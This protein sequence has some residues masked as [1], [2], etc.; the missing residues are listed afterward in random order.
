MKI[1][2]DYPLRRAAQVAADVLALVVIALGIWLGATVT[3]AIAV[4]GEVGRQLNLAGLGFQGAMADAANVLGQAPFIG[5]AA[6]A[7]FDSAS[8]TGAVIA[9]AGSSTESFILTTAAIVGVIIALAI[10][11]AVLWVW[12]RRRIA[13]IRRA[14]EA[15]RLATMGDG[16]DLLALRALVN[17]S[18]ADLAATSAH[19]VDAWRSGE[20]ALVRKLAALELRGAG[21]RPRVSPAR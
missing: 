21:V 6:R 3:A 13:F 10:G 18:R 5:D 19:P 9:D 12:L 14:T 16:H 7:P 1:Y 20:P 4:L 17:G 8:E 2:S 11:A 15:S